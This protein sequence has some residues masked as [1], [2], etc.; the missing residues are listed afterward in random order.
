[1]EDLIVVGIG[2]ERYIPRIL[3]LVWEGE[4][5]EHLNENLM[6]MHGW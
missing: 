6:A 4:Y 3:N 1:M 2:L 5:R